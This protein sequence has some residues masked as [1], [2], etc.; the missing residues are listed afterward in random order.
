MVVLGMLAEFV[1]LLTCFGE[2]TSVHCKKET[3]HHARI[4]P[5]IRLNLFPSIPFSVYFTIILP[6]D[7]V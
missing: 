4:M 3:S 5:Q 7:A 1:M 6:F 2:V